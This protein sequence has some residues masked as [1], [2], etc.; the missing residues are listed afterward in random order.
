MNEWFEKNDRWWKRIE[1]KIEMN[2]PMK[3]F[4]IWKERED[5]EMLK[6]RNWERNW[7]RDPPIEKERKEIELILFQMN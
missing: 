1:K 4:E 3:N 7:E 6:E 2:D 5:G